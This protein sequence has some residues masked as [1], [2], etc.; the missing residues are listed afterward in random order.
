[1]AAGMTK[2]AAVMAGGGSNEAG[3]MALDGAE[4]TTAAMGVA[5]ETAR[6][7][8]VGGRM[9]R[10]GGKERWAGKLE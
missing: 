8:A 6:T 4:T 9:G 3:T 10:D 2:T 1:M 5:G 7:A